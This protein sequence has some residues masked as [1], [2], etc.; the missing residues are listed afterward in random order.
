MH[1]ASKNGD[2]LPLIKKY[3]QRLEAA[4]LYIDS[5]R[6]YCW[7]VRSVSD[8]KFAPFHLLDLSGHPNP[9]M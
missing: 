8:L 4:K 1:L 9:A 3:K 2:A 6:R 7:L 5:Y